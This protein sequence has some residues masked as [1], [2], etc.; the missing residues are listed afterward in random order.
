LR[1]LPT[2]LTLRTGGRHHELV[3]SNYHISYEEA[4]R[5]QLR[6]FHAAATGAARVSIS[7]EQAKR[8]IALLISA[9]RKSPPCA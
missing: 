8:D 5:E 1:H 9:F 2:K 6:A 3:H 4:F 7:V